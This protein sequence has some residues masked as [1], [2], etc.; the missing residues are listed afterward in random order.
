MAA[1]GNE[2]VGRLD[3]AVNDAFGMCGFERVGSLNGEIQQEVHGKGPARDALLQRRALDQLHH[4]EMMALD[5]S[6]LVDGADVGMVQ[7]G[8][9]SGLALESL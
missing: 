9:S 8:G 7:G 5:F 4:Q 6:D 2:D 1:L 3:V